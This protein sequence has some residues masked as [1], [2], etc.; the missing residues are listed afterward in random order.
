MDT[1]DLKQQPW[2]LCFEKFHAKFLKRSKFGQPLPEVP[3]FD[4]NGYFL[5]MHGLKIQI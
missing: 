5:N 4:K 3:R 2:T 1:P